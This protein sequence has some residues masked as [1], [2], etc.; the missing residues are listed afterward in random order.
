MKISVIIP[1]YNASCYLDASVTSVVRAAQVASSQG[2]KVEI[3]LIDDGS[4]DG[5]SEL[6]VGLAGQK[7]EGVTWL[8]RR[9]ANSGAGRA[10]NLGI[11][12]ATGD[13]LLFV[14]ADDMIAETTFAR[15]HEVACDAVDMIGFS[16]R[17]LL[18]EVTAFE[19]EQ[20]NGREEVRDLTGRL[21]Y[22][23]FW[24]N[25]WTCCYRRSIVPEAGFP[26]YV[27]GEDLVFL[28]GAFVKARRMV[29]LT[30][31]LYGYR[32]HQ[33]SAIHSGMTMRKL[34]DYLRY[35]LE[36]IEILR[37][38]G[39]LMDSLIYRRIGLEL[40]ENAVAKILQMTKKEEKKAWEQWYYALD[41]CRLHRHL[42]TQWTRLVIVAC[43]WLPLR[44]V[45]YGLCV[46]PY[47]L[48]VL[49]FHR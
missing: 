2:V 11:R 39:K 7:I 21:E 29:E 24:R 26:P 23:I 10:R 33:G 8:I 42:F 15:L 12:C 13:W 47:R 1:V 9:Q 36:R 46:L 14:D 17:T 19:E 20:P 4:T 49:G 30:D 37:E 5:S 43:S 27:V 38:S 32:I 25:F 3:V 40:T 34:S 6:L 35:N 41:R 44:I 45:A 28:A 18:E 16:Y 48:K 22:G 31:K